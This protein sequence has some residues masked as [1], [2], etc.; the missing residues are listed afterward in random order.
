MSAVSTII[1]GESTLT[2]GN[3]T[4]LWTLIDSS[5]KSAIA[6]T[7]FDSL[8]V[9]S[10]G[11]V[12]TYPVEQGA[13]ASY[14][15]VQGP[16]G[17]KVTL[18]TW[19]EESLFGQILNKLEEYKQQAATLTVVTPARAYTN[20]TL[21]SYGYTRKQDN[22]AG[23]LLVDLDLVE[24]REVAVGVTTQVV[25]VPKKTTRKKAGK[26][27]NPTSNDKKNTG[28][29]QPKEGKGVLEILRK[30]AKEIFF[31]RSEEKK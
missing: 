8:N 5:G 12:L 22:G 13:F 28:K 14:N 11:K 25:A 30:K 20:M 27:K 24:V 19:G 1:A 23:M 26:P 2:P 17:I 16:L 29:V 4:H 3:M 21:Q 7:S 9:K 10:E 15:K 6:F 31:P 18:G